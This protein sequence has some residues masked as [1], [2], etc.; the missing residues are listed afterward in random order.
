MALALAPLAVV[1]GS[2]R[3][4]VDARRSPDEERSASSEPGGGSERLC[5]LG[6]IAAALLALVLPI[7]HG[8]AWDPLELDAAELARRI[9]VHAFGES[10]LGRAGDP[11]GLP[12]LSDLGSGE[13]PFTAIAAAFALLGVGDV[14]GRLPAALAGLAGVL[15]L[16]ALVAR[17]AGGRAALYAVVVLVTMPLYALHA[18]SMAGESSSLASFTLAFAGLGLAA[19]ELGGRR[20][21]V[22]L[23]LGALGLVAGFLSR[24][25]L[26]GVATPLIAVGLA[27]LVSGEHLSGWL[28][29]SRR[30]YGAA[31]L[32]GGLLALG[33]YLAVALPK[34][35][36]GA[37]L[38][39]L[40][41]S[42]LDVPAG[43]AASFDRTFRQLGH[44]LFP[45]AAILPFALGRMLSPGPRALPRALSA[46]DGFL[47]ILLLSVAG[48]GLAAH[49]L[50]VPWSG[51]LP[52]VAVS[53]LA[54][55][56]G[57]AFAEL[58]RGAP[59]SLTVALGAA[60]LAAVLHLDL[61]RAPGRALSAF[62]VDE[63]S[64]DRIAEAGA[65]LPATSALFVV[66]VTLA[67]VDRRAVGARPGVHE[68]G[69]R[70]RAYLRESAAELR[71]SARALSEAWQGNLL[72]AAVLLEAA[73]F[74]LGAMLWLGRL[75]AWPSIQRLPA[76]WSALGLH[77]W[78]AVPSAGLGGLLGA[79]L[80]RDAT[81]A[82]AALA[83]VPR[84]RVAAAVAVLG[85]ALWGLGHQPA[86]AARLSASDAFAAY[87]R[88]AKP[89]E[90][91][92][93]L[94]LSPSAGSHHLGRA[95][96]E[97]RDAAGAFRW[98]AAPGGTRRFLVF[99]RKHL[100]ELNAMHRGLHRA[101]LPVIAEP[102]AD[103]LLACTELGTRPSE[104]PL[105]RFF[106][107][108]RPAVSRALGAVLDDRVEIV[109]W[110]VLDASGS[111]VEALH[112]RRPYLM[113]VVYEV[114]APLPAGYDAFFHIDGH[115]RRHNG[116]HPLLEG[117]YPTQL[118]QPGDVLVDEHPFEL[119]ANFGPGTYWLFM[120]LNSG[121]T[122]LPVTEGDHRDDRVVAGKLEVR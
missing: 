90:E 35:G 69:A 4:L 119:G 70:S 89:G 87:V 11:E 8:G 24:G 114:R 38:S 51:P 106:R 61:A 107:K 20:R 44:A 73:L 81:R 71:R 103:T 99:K 49:A 37:P 74:G 86:L 64:L 48:V 2:V 112:A 21:A 72:F 32:A 60:V 121:T 67:F 77:A 98:F 53:A 15:A 47:R 88:E 111:V 9:A 16:H 97:F 26:L 52:Y 33:V 1:R 50:L 23:V 76:G 115:D 46:G 5:W 14:V 56:V 13:L 113:R 17:L 54:A 105:D 57:V 62:P 27:V 18:R 79:V 42:S 104:N 118:W 28:G 94:G 110:E 36:A 122:R 95:L 116:D 7:F 3:R 43:R 102:S 22:A 83:G 91:L 120:G 29:S 31:L 30:R 59:R 40:V 55:S 25:L 82:V 80:L 96:P 19:I 58:E 10:E 39:R 65:W 68:L 100:A 75:L 41:G 12:T 84:S 109:G 78:W 45:W 66:G 93:Q 92:A 6:S 117:A 85:A 108:E 63:P 34:V 101:Q